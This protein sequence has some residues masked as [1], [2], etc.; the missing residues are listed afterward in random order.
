M[1]DLIKTEK[2]SLPQDH[3]SVHA[4]NSLKKIDKNKRKDSKIV[5]V[6]VFICLSPKALEVLET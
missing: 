2:P 4:V 5:L 3:P 1:V 6:F